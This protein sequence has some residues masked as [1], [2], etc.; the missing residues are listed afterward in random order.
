MTELL[1]LKVYPPTLT[2]KTSLTLDCNSGSK[3]IKTSVL[4][5]QSLPFHEEKSYTVCANT[6][7]YDKPYTLTSHFLNLLVG[8][9]VGCFGLNGFFETVLQSVSNCLPE[10]GRKK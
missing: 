2:V 1:P 9:L 10:R 8:W 6:D 4:K 5:D 7:D 3:N